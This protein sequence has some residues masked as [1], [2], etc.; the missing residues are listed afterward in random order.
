M[1]F[2]N[3]AYSETRLV[4]LSRKEGKGPLRELDVAVL[5]QGGGGYINTRLTTSLQ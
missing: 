2:R 3:I 4:R 5:R 1:R